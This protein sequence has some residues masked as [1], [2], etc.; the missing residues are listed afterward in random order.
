LRETRTSTWALTRRKMMPQR[1][2]RSNFE[3]EIER[4][5]GRRERDGHVV[6]A[7][8]EDEADYGYMTST[9]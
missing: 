7:D 5:G 4:I 3:D 9:G 6:G 1:R 2:R 8:D